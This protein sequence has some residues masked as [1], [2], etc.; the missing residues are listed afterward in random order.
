[1]IFEIEMLEIV[2]GAEASPAG[3]TPAD[4]K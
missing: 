3:T 2:D 1:L 4:N